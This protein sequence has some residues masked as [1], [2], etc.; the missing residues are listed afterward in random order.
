[1]RKLRYGSGCWP[2]I[3]LMSGCLGWAIPAAAAMPG[4]GSAAPDF[5]LHSSTG[6]NLKLSEYRGRVVMINF[7]A[8]WCGP[9]RQEMPHLNRLYA[10]YQ[11]A[12]FMLV[13]VNVDDD[14]KNARAMADQLGVR[15]PVLYDRDK[16]VSRRYDVDAMPATVILD[17]DGKVRYLHRGY[18]AGTE[19]AYETQLRELLKQ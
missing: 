18:R 16:Q 6:K 8:T 11:R 10:Q 1:M 17:R 19:K 2:A 7:W 14:P 3:V 4:P 5:T 12:G 9:C 13:G 15:F